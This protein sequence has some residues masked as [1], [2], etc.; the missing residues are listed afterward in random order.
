MVE[1]ERIVERD[2]GGNTA[3]IIGALVALLVV[4]LLLFLFLGGN[5]GND[6]G[7]SGTGG[8]TNIEVETPDAPDVEAPEGGTEG[9][10]ET[11]PTG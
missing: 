5:N 10:P 11:E 7:G 8:D 9:E 4:G 2:G 3:A 6:D 1:R